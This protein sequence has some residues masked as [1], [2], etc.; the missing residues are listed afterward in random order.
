MNVTTFSF[1]MAILWFSAFVL[2]SYMIRRKTGV[3]LQFS[4]F[5]LLILSA[6]CLIRIMVPLEF[7]FTV[8]VRS[9][10]LFPFIQSILDRNVMLLGVQVSFLWCLVSTCL[11]VSIVLLVRFFRDLHRSAVLVELLYTEQDE[12]AQAMLQGIATQTAPGTVCKVFVAPDLNSPIVTGLM[13]PV[14]LMPERCQALE[15]K[16]LEHIL[17]HEWCH[18]TSKDLWTKLWIHILCCLMWWNPLVYLLKRNLDQVLELNCDQRVTRNMTE[19]GRIEYLE[20]LLAVLK[21]RTEV[22]SHFLQEAVNASFLGGNKS[23]DTVQ[24]FEMIYDHQKSRASWKTNLAMILVMVSLLIASYSF[25]LQPYIPA[26]EGFADP[27]MPTYHVISPDNAY[28][29]AEEDG[30]YSLFVNGQ[31]FDIITENDLN[32]EPYNLLPI[33]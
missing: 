16:Q 33:S 21:Q 27:G 6:I 22:E 19:L 32:S 12:R 28:L 18:F 14:I 24:R 13:N 2:L 30:T 11:L 9:T 17:R 25:I 4:L 23:E 10:K 26:E 31:L 8:V 3:L 20:T 7:P 15:D 1:L 29:Q 5:P